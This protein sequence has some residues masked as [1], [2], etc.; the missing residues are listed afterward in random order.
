LKGQ[1]QHFHHFL[2]DFLP[3]LP[4]LV[5]LF[6]LTHGFTVGYF[7]PSLRDFA[8]LRLCAF[9]LKYSSVS[10]PSRDDYA[11]VSRMISRSGVRGLNFTKRSSFSTSGLRRR[12][13]SG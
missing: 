2:C 6:R 5:P 13:L 7:L 12:A 10:R 3:P 1:P 11:A 8:A 9:A 4:G